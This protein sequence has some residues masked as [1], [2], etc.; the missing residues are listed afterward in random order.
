M[1]KV[2]TFKPK[3]RSEA[4]TKVLYLESRFKSNVAML[5]DMRTKLLKLQRDFKTLKRNGIKLVDNGNDSGDNT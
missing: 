2:Y 1:A 4:E 3:Q 5:A